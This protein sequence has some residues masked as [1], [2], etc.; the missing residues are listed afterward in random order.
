MKPRNILLVARWEVSRPAKSKFSLMSILLL[1]LTIVLLPLTLSNLSFEGYKISLGSYHLYR[2]GVNDHSIIDDLREFQRIDPVY[3][4][5]FEGYEKLKNEQIDILILKKEENVVIHVPA[6][7]KGAAGFNELKRD[8]EALNERHINEKISENDSMHYILKPIVIE[9]NFLEP[10]IVEEIEGEAEEEKT[11][12]AEVSELPEPESMEVITPSSLTLPF[13]FPS[14]IP[15]FIFVAPVFFF[16]LFFASSILRE[17][18]KRVGECL[19]ASPITSSEIILGK[20]SP[21]LIIVL[22]TSIL[23]MIALGNFS[24]WVILTILPITLAS[25][26]MSAIVAILSKSPRDMNFTLMFF[27]LSFFAYLFY[28]MLFVDIHPISALSPI[29][30]MSQAIEENGKADLFTFT[31]ALLP[32]LFLSV[33]SLIF[34]IGMFREEVLFTQR[35]VTDKLYAVFDLFDIIWGSLGKY[36]SW[37]AAFLAG[38]ILIPAVYLLEL[39]LLF[40]LFPLGGGLLI[41]L[42]PVVAFSE[43]LAKIFGV[44]AFIRGGKIKNGFLF[45]AVSGAGFFFAEKCLSLIYLTEFLT[46]EGKAFLAAEG[47]WAIL[48]VQILCSAIAGYGFSLTRGKFSF[49]SITFLLTAIVLHLIFYIIILL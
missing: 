48:F 41:I 39:A 27:Y 40:L 46:E 22:V 35:S 20:L 13:P 16:S 45:G 4:D 18:I 30:L 31:P 36:A 15:A 26:G 44:A 33:I 5:R 7:D 38:V 49:K 3:V 43:E 6:S 19:L 8:F 34:S 23:A 47:M 28:P 25:M 11:P 29:T 2:T 21:Y 24:I 42:L 1:L 32:I 9:L 37:T 12:G 10:Q 17:K 14:P